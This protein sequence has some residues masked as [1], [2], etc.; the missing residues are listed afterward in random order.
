MKHNRGGA[1]ESRSRR[2]STISSS[3]EHRRERHAQHVASRRR[4]IGTNNNAKGGTRGEKWRE[5]IAGETRVQFQRKTENVLE[6]KKKKFVLTRKNERQTEKSNAYDARAARR[7]GSMVVGVTPA[8][9][10]IAHVFPF[11]TD[12]VS[13]AI[14]E[15]VKDLKKK[16]IADVARDP[17]VRNLFSIRKTGAA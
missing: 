3:R 11:Q 6:K 15:G 1:E 13:R 5:K 9:T 7:A 4:S 2:F 8:E 14:R 12:S 17:R 10:R 16:A